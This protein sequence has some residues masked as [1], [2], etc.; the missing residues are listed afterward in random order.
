[1]ADSNFTLLGLWERQEEQVEAQPGT[2]P[3]FAR[4]IPPWFSTFWRLDKS[5]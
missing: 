5:A 4:V 2:W 1:M 3:H